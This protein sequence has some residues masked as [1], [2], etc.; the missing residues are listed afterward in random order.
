[1]ENVDLTYMNTIQAILN[2]D[3]DQEE[4]VVILILLS[5]ELQIDT[6]SSTARRDGKTPSG[7]RR[8]K[9]YRKV[10]IGSQVMAIKLKQ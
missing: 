9:K 8:S 3:F 6:I 4:M 10:D 1:M 7:V 5:N 2:N